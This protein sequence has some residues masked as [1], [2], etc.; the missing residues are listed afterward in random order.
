MTS[1]TTE[2]SWGRRR[3]AIDRTTVEPFGPRTFATTSCSVKAAGSRAVDGEQDV[4]L[5]ESRRDRR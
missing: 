1:R 4:D 3:D 5:Q 2:M